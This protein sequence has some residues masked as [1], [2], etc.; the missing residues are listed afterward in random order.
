MDGLEGS[1]FPQATGQELTSEVLVG[2]MRTNGSCY[3]VTVDQEMFF[4]S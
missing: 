1:S 2:V 3:S 4:S